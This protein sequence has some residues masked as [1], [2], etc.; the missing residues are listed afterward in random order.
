MANRGA[1]EKEALGLVSEALGSL[2][3]LRKAELTEINQ[4]TKHLYLK[5]LLSSCVSSVQNWSV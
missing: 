3:H 5:T 4:Q 2:L 1:Y